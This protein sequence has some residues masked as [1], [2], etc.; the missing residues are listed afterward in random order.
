MQ[1]LNIASSEFDEEDFNSPPHPTT[2]PP[3]P[4]GV[5]THADADS[6]SM[7]STLSTSTFCTAHSS[8]SSPSTR[9]TTATSAPKIP[10]QLSIQPPSTTPSIHAPHC[11]S[12]TPRTSSLRS[13]P[14]SSR[15]LH[16]TPPLHQSPTNV[17]VCV[18][19]RWAFRECGCEGPS[20]V[21]S[22]ICD[23]TDK[24]EGGEREGDRGEKRGGRD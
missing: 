22:C 12:L 19:E 7:A 17:F 13:P 14:A 6:A 16:S 11:P 21:R 10:A 4:L 1:A 24:T 15:L 23:P 5:Q 20:L 2:P 3:V 8:L 18:H 9:P